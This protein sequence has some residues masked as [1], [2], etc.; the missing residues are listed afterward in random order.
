MATAPNLKVNIGAD[1]SDFEKGAKEVK[2]GLKDLSKTGESALGALG[3]AFGVNTGKIG[4]MTSAIKG[5]GQKMTECGNVG[6]KAF[7]DLLKGITPLQAGIAGLGLAAAVA[8]FKQ[9]KAA[10]ENFKSTIDGMNM[11]M[12]T[13]AYIS[14][15]KQ[16]LYDVNSETGKQVAEAMDKWQ[17]GFGKFKAQLGATFVTAAGQDQKWYD[18]FLPTGV[19]RAWNTVK[20]ASEDAEAAA[21]RNADRASQIADIR[22]Q[23]LQVRKDIADIDVEIAEQRRI[24]RDRSKSAEERSAAEAAVRDKIAQKT[25]MQKGMAQQ[26]YELQSAMTGE[27][28]STYEQMRE[29]TDLYVEWKNISVQETDQMAT[30][31]RYSNSIAGNTSAAAKA[32]KEY[33]DQLKKMEAVKSKWSGM[34]TV[35]TAGL[36][37]VSGGVIG[38]SLSILPQEQDTELFKQTFLAQLGEIKVGIGFEADTQKI[39][40][41]TSEVNSLLTSAVGRTS[42]IIGNLIGNLAAGGDAWGDFKNAAISAFGDMAIAVGKIAVAAG[43]ATLGIKAAFESMN[44]YA[45]IAAGAALIALGSAVKSSL[46]AVASGDYSASGGGYSSSYSSGGGGN[47]YETRDVNVYVTGS[48]EADGDK[49]IAVINNTN[50]K[51]Y[52]TR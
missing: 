52:Y 37:N 11:S 48:L 40:D 17:R 21:T 43:V 42:E 38:P 12:A 30:I 2:Q 23:E 13:S 10:A 39:H 9:L 28:G 18:A 20:A 29:V 47:G 15:Y 5:A 51:N 46:S 3:S 31:D 41:I 49:L 26:L 50:K 16:V 32:A 6:V 34:G 19:I 27:A 4:E 33:A 7:G 24:I 25:E 35:S 1:T 22:K 14:T 36:G 44:G 8:G 45:A